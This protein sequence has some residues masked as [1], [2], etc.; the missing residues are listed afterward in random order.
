MR[1]CRLNI[2]SYVHTSDVLSIYQTDIIQPTLIAVIDYYFSRV[3]E[4]LRKTRKVI[5]SKCC[6]L[7]VTEAF[8]LSFFLQNKLLPNQA[9]KEEFITRH[10]FWFAFGKNKWSGELDVIL[11]NI[12]NAINAAEEVLF[13]HSKEWELIPIIDFFVLCHEQI[14]FLMIPISA[15]QAPDDYYRVCSRSNYINRFF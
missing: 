10:T 13:S 3:E 14:I 4:S 8:Y 2:D 5:W 15:E 9:N 12:D 1:L 7:S 11:F 6:L